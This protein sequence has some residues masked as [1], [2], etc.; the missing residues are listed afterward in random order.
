MVSNATMGNNDLITRVVYA[1]N[2]SSEPQHISKF[3]L[4]KLQIFP[5]SSIPKEALYCIS[6]LLGVNCKQQIFLK[7]RLHFSGREKKSVKNILGSTIVV[8]FLI[9]MLFICSMA[10]FLLYVFRNILKQL[11]FYYANFDM[12][13]SKVAYKNSLQCLS[14]RV[15]DTL[16]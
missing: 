11:V 4:S 16:Y 2:L 1:R 8:L 7:I 9:E 5:C 13:S 15:S 12:F 14:S 3:E 6:K 10:F